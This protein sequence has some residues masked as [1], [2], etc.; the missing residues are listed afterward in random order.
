LR[1]VLSKSKWIISQFSSI[2]QISPQGL[3]LSKNVMAIEHEYSW[4]VLTNSAEG[5]KK[6]V[7]SIVVERPMLLLVALVVQNPTKKK[8]V[9]LCN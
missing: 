2:N 7:I 8:I 5:K 3:F 6:L 4:S 9:N 1:K